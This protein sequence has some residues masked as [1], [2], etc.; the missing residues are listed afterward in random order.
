[1]AGD[2]RAAEILE[3]LSR[4]FDHRNDADI[5]LSRSELIGALRGQSEAKI[6]HAALFAVEHAPY[7]RDGVQ[8]TDRAHTRPHNGI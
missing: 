3:L 5:S 7:Q 8:I 1:M 4:H 2:P 6:E